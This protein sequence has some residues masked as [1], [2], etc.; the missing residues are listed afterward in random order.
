MTTTLAHT[1][2]TATLPNCT[3]CGRYTSQPTVRTWCT[4][5]NAMGAHYCGEDLLCPR[6]ATEQEA[7]P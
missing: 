2:R 7:T 5:G 6:C 1:G 3:K 4:G